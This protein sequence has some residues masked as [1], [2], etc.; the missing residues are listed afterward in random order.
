MPGKSE[1]GLLLDRLF[2]VDLVMLLILD[3]FN[4]FSMPLRRLQTQGA[5][6]FPQP[7]APCVLFSLSTIEP[8]DFHQFWCSYSVWAA[9]LGWLWLIHDNSV[10]G[11]RITGCHGTEPCQDVLCHRRISMLS[12]GQKCKLALGAAFWTRPRCFFHDDLHRLHLDLEKKPSNVARRPPDIK[13]CRG[14]M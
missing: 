13:K 6:C 1:A 14:H 9:I 8:S 12:S 5:K 2:H 10:T 4:R 7:F 11:R 3:C